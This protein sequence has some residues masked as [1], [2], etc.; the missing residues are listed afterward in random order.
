MKAFILRNNN[1]KNVTANYGKK[2]CP[3]NNQITCGPLAGRK[4]KN[5]VKGR[6][7]RREEKREVGKNGWGCTRK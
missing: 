1:K 3:I 4:G 6:K 2:K 5:G 7:E